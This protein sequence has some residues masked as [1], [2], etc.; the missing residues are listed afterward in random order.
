MASRL[1][2]G[3]MVRFLSSI[4]LLSIFTSLLV[5]AQTPDTATIRGR[6]VDQMHGGIAGAD[7][8]V[9]NRLTGR[10]QTV[11]TDAIG[12]FY[13][14][15]LPVSG[16]YSASAAKTGFASA[17]RDDISLIGGSTANVELILNVAGGK[18]E[19]TVVGALDEVRIDE[20]QFGIHLDAGQIHD[21]PLYG[22]KL[23]YLPLLNAAPRP[24]VNQGDI[25]MNQD[26]FT[27]NGSGRRQTWFEVDGSNANDSWGRQ[28]IFTNIPLVAVDE[29]SVLT[30]SFSAEYGGSTGSVVNIITKSGGNQYHGEVL[31][32]WRPSGPEAA[33]SGFTPGNATSG[34]DIANDTLG[35]SSAAISGP[36][37]AEKLTHFFLGGEYSRQDRASPVTSVLAPGN[38]IGHYRDWL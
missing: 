4:V 16:S 9:T 12:S 35:Q 22:R 25:F 13:V 14:G 7:V 38:F 21:T 28:T 18:T 37:G 11:T 19:V 31:E 10:H 3:F 26:L 17:N 20:P 29:M 15:G 30:N 8:T 34:N 1:V 5:S 23:T 36:I 6:V 24:A 27:T 2:K 33:L 32:L